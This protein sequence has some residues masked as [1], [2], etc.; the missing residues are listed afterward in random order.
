MAHVSRK[1]EIL[2]GQMEQ[3]ARAWSRNFPTE[4]RAAMDEADRVRAGLYRESGMSASR[5]FMVKRTITNRLDGVLSVLYGRSWQED[6]EISASFDRVFKSLVIN[7][8]SVPKIGGDYVPAVDYQAGD[9]EDNS[10]FNL[11]EVY[12]QLNG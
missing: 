10:E 6:P 11:L 2:D 9:S 5:L 7:H 12:K 8:T 3:I 1:K 4:Y